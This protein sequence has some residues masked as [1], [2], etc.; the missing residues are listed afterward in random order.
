MRSP[1][2]PIKSQTVFDRERDHYQLVNL[3]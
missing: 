3:G 1:N 2:D